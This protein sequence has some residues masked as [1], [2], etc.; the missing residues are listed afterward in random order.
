MSRMCARKQFGVGAKKL[1]HGSRG[2]LHAGFES[3]YV[4][5]SGDA[6]L[7]AL[8]AGFLGSGILC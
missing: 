8:P 5:G 4:K 7:S 6:T 1:P 2:K 3:T